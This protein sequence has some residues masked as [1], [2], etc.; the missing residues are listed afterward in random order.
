MKTVLGHEEWLR[1]VN[2]IVRAFRIGGSPAPP[3]KVLVVT[4]RGPMVAQTAPQ[5]P[6]PQISVTEAIKALR[7][8]GLSEGYARHLLQRKS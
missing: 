4:S 8:L 7:K 6:E 5:A 1:Q 2:A 3:S